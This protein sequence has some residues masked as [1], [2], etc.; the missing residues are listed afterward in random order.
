M[1]HP[2]PRLP[3][4]YT[5]PPN[6]SAEELEVWAIAIEASI[7]H[8]VVHKLSHQTTASQLFLDARFNSP[9]HQDL[10]YYHACAYLLTATRE[11]S[12]AGDY[13]PLIAELFTLLKEEG[14][15]RDKDRSAHITWGRSVVFPF[16][17][18]IIAEIPAP[19]GYILNEIEFKLVPDAEYVQ[20]DATYL[21]DVAS[22]ARQHEGMIRFWSLVGRLEAMRVYGD[23]TF[24]DSWSLMCH[25]GESLLRALEQ[26]ALRG[27]WETL[28]ASVPMLRPGNGQF[29]SGECKGTGSHDERTQEWRASFLDAARR[30]AGDERASM[31]WRGRF[32]IIVD[33]LERG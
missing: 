28:W 6:E 11:H 17:R 29:P 7:N 15:R 1:S 21:R 10:L 33:S 16:L 20:D 14:L 5:E 25:S 27:A 31:E 19:P 18:A 8:I 4:P 23:G 9:L 12:E 24:A 26:P 22:Y 30:I 3:K 32:A 2:A 13:I